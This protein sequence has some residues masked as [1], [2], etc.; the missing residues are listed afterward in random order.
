MPAIFMAFSAIAAEALRV[1]EIPLSAQYVDEDAISAFFVKPAD[2]RLED[3]VVVQLGF[4]RSRA[5]Y[6]RRAGKA[7]END[8]QL[9]G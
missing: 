6:R 2:R 9:S 3:A 1:R 7:I 8:S 4:L 5:H